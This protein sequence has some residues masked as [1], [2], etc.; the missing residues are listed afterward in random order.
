MSGRL[1]NAWVTERD[2]LSN[3]TGNTVRTFF[4]DA[5]GQL[6]QRSEKKYG[7][8]YYRTQSYYYRGDNPL[9]DLGENGAN[10]SPITSLH[11]GG[12]TP[13][14]YTIREGDSLSLVA[15]AM[16]GDS[17]LWYVIAQANG[18]TKGPQDVFSD[19][20]I[21]RTLSIPNTQQNLRNDSTT[22]KP[23][24][25]AEIIGD[26]T[27]DVKI[28][29][30]PQEGCNAVAVLVM[31]VVA[32]VVT[33]ITA[34]AA[35]TLVAGALN[36]ALGATAAGTVGAVVG[37]FVGGFV[38]SMASQAVGVALGV[39]DKID[40]DTVRSSALTSAFTYGVGGGGAHIDKVS[41]SLGTAAA[42]FARGALNYLVN[43]VANKVTGVDSSFSW[44]GMLA[45][46]AG[47]AA[48]NSMADGIQLGGGFWSRTA[49]GAMSSAATGKFMH[50]WN[51][52]ET[53][54]YGLIALDAFGNQLGSWLG[55]GGQ[56]PGQA[57]GGA[58]HQTAEDGKDTAKESMRDTSIENA[59]SSVD[60]SV[61]SQSERH[62]RDVTR[63]RQP[64][65]ITPIIPADEEV[66]VT[67]HRG[68]NGTEFYTTAEVVTRG[69]IQN[70]TSIKGKGGEVYNV[71]SEY[72]PS[73]IRHQ[74]AQAA[75]EWD[76]FMATQSRGVTISDQDIALGV[77]AHSMDMTV[78]WARDDYNEITGNIRN[79]VSETYDRSDN[80]LTIYG[81]SVLMGV[82][83]TLLYATDRV[84]NLAE[85][86]LSGNARSNVHSD[87]Y[88]AY[89]LL[90][91]ILK[92]DTDF[93]FSLKTKEA[94]TLKIVGENLKANGVPITSPEFKIMSGT[95]GLF[96]WQ[97]KGDVS[98]FLHSD[99]STDGNTGI[100]FRQNPMELDWQIL[101]DDWGWEPKFEGF[102][103]S[104]SIIAQDDVTKRLFGG[105]WKFGYRTGYTQNYE[106]GDQTISVRPAV[107]IPVP[108]F[109]KLTSRFG[110]QLNFEIRGPS[111][112]TTKSGG[113]H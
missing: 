11:T 70:F 109:N 51:G 66:I 44:K 19:D 15:Q 68:G 46:A 21:G 99:I 87:V 96:R 25:P 41:D 84:A 43:H 60:D 64:P 58:K 18:I 37:G 34:G 53:P 54:N 3:S 6:I 76:A 26:L 108:F 107:D 88:E 65:E 104:Y 29:P 27:P 50:Q 113:V 1:T 24:N 85:Y 63:V 55:A 110:W 5:E 90:K 83:E 23:Y 95:D 97:V 2:I 7:S 47:S 20:E 62:L 79:Y 22:F 57:T 103:K 42:H 10:F 74:T 36:E 32:V 59:Q 81:T 72:V 100:A 80:L 17:S 91:G 33:Y 94:R 71:R 4:Y 35:S 49:R 31:V 106:T 8:D 78:G 30:P 14:S 89:T 111:A 82:S 67:G 86:T 9:A 75:K 28:L 38:G 56:M 69:V 98:R 105:D 45:Y 39:Q 102:E 12:D 52:A 73:F 112:T 61:D 40:W 16:F 93:R 92:D 13:S 48:G 101:S 77:N